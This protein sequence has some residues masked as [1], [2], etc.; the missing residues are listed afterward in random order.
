MIV[1]MTHFMTFVTRLSVQS[2]LEFSRTLLSPPL[3]MSEGGKLFFLFKEPIN[4][5]QCRYSMR[6]CTSL[7][8]M[9]FF[10]VTFYDQSFL[11][12]S[13]SLKCVLGMSQLHAHIPFF[14]LEVQALI[15]CHSDFS[16]QHFSSSSF[17]YLHC[18][19]LQASMAPHYL[20]HLHFLPLHLTNP[21]PPILYYVHL[22]YSVWPIV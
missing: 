4:P 13:R 1:S 11:V 9:S 10:E 16:L 6:T 15:R 7:L 2:T 22:H 12:F 19:L 21:N 5:M 18:W 3:S 17:L 20:L 8:P 14:Y